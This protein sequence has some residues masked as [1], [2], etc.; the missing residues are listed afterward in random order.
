M[1]AL[2]LLGFLLISC[3]QPMP[4]GEDMGGEME[5]TRLRP[6]WL[7]GSDGSRYRAAG[8]F[9]DAQLK[10]PCGLYMY[11]GKAYCVPP[12]VQEPLDTARYVV[13]SYS[14]D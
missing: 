12:P 10:A 6:M 2:P 1:R 13:I 8:Y 5:G 7:N 3:G 14:N 11:Q 4:G 9:Y